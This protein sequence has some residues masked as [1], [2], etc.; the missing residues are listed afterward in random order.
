MQLTHRHHV[1]LEERRHVLRGE[2]HLLSAE[3]KLKRQTQDNRKRQRP[4]PIATLADYQGQCACG[5]DVVVITDVARCALCHWMQGVCAN[6][7]VAQNIVERQGHAMGPRW[8]RN[9]PYYQWRNAQKNSPTLSKAEWDALQ[10]QDCAGCSAR[11]WHDQ[12][13]C[14]IWR[15][16]W[17]SLCKCCT[18]L[19]EPF[20]SLAEMREHM[21]RTY[22]PTS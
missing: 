4:A 8:S 22:S 17:L 3:D 10:Q 13:N 14:P 16:E 12:W 6:Q 5:A 21:H 11:S 18:L 9:P 7:A 20:A 15:G 19:C 2:R 1:D